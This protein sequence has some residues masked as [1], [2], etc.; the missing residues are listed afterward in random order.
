MKKSE[1]N[2]HKLLFSRPNIYLA[3]YSVES[4]ISDKVL[5]SEVDAKE[6]IQLRDK[7]NEDNIERW[8]ERVQ[9][10]LFQVIDSTHYLQAKVFFKPKKYDE[11]ND[12][13]IFRP[14][15]SSS[16]LDQITAVAMLNI[17]I[18]EFDA[19]NK[20][21]MSNL[22]RLIPHNF[23]GNRVAYEPEKLFK[24]WQEQYK[25]YTSKAND[26][27]RSFHDNGEYR[28]EVN[29][30]LEN[31]FPSINPVCLYNYVVQQMSVE[32]TEDD[33]KTL[34]KILEKLIFVKIDSLDEDE[35][36]MYLGPKGKQGQD[37][38]F[39]MGLP[40]GLPQ[41]YFLANLF[42]VEVE[43]IY[44]KVLPGEMVF[45][46]DDSAVFTNEI[47]DVTDFE[48]K[49]KTINNDI[50]RWMSSLLDSEKAN[51]LSKELCEYVGDRAELYIIN[52]HP[53]G[54]KSTISNIADSKKGEEYLHCI[55]REASKTAFDMNT[56]FSDEESKIL[57]NKTECIL[58]VVNRELEQ[59]DEELRDKL[60]GEDSKKYLE[61]YKKKLI[62]YK[63]FF[64][65]RSKDLQYSERNDVKSLQEEILKDL[66]F[67]DEKTNSCEKIKKFF[68]M[69]NED[70]LG[71]AIAFVLRSMQ[72]KG[73]NN[74]ELAKKI[75]A[76]NKLLFGKDNKESSY[77]YLSYKKYIEDFEYDVTETM[78]YTTLRRVVTARTL[79]VRKK[80]DKLKVN[81]VKGEL[82]K[83]SEEYPVKDIM[84]KGFCDTASLVLRNSDELQRQCINS[85]LSSL[86]QIEISDDVIL[87][88]NNNRKITYSELRMLVYLR[89]KKFSL[90]DFMKM[91][92]DFVQEEYQCAIDY[93]IIQVLSVFRTFVSVPAYI[94]NLILVHKYTCDIWKNGSKHLHFYTLHNQE[95]AVDLIQNSIK[96]I[97]AIDYISISK[98]DYYVLFIAC[99]LHDISMV[100]F[101]NLDLLL[102]DSFESNQIYSNFV[103]EVNKEI[104]DSKLAMR[105]VK[106]LLKDYYIRVDAFYE[107][108]V[109]ENH[110]KN[111]ATEIRNRN[112]LGFIDRSLREIV[113][114]ISEAHGYE[115]NDIYKIK[116]TASSKVWSQKFTKIIL[117]LADLL[118]MSNY[119]VS[120]LVL[121]HNLDN[122][123]KTSRFHWLSHLITTGY[124]IE[125]DYYLD[126]AKKKNFLERHSIVENIVL[127]VDVG[128]PQ[129]THEPSCDCKNMRLEKIE[130]KTVHLKSGQK[131]TGE[132]CNFLCKWFKRKNEYLF[133]ELA[134]L[135]EYLESLPNN[136]FKPEIEVQICSSDKNKLSP[137]QF[138]LLK[139]YV[140]G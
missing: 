14:L 21:S 113:A 25:Q 39:A 117:R 54:D 62:R 27:Y 125:T 120:A 107:K 68:D 69:Y 101:P 45:Y 5:L 11:E 7:F 86:L 115:V 131:C 77:L 16:L 88:K 33:R 72:E 31:F 52:I 110:A 127:K 106:R 136:Y 116:S 118:D 40:Q 91:I 85:M 49:I 95:H 74:S 98:S 36:S 65:Y 129:M 35:L 70:T 108:L 51:E 105:P 81:L 56:S 112:E 15:H 96:I 90:N 133:L 78:K 43:K 138:T 71:V 121:N 135:Q 6:L 128:L 82:K 67:L 76:L 55:G 122:M 99:Y 13:V 20:I 50:A 26:Y 132:E 140:D 79:Y 34:C 73:D 97:R 28:W 32:Y 4:Y 123:G 92:E 24:P 60:L 8:I 46:V 64:K 109:R 134:S 126:S 1:S 12:R 9:K 104:Q 19:D 30:D 75:V 44:K 58:Q 87:Q 139:Q 130:Q 63:K 83:I 23:Y 100:T 41:S 114:E 93:S 89:N 38:T 48:N 137:K 119:R 10:R 17:L 61:A 47:K 102:A 84:S 29:L 42:M 37:C 94:D 124:E 59:I 111:S 57:L 18:Y 80:T 66:Q 103:N 22:S 53:P 2:V 3:L